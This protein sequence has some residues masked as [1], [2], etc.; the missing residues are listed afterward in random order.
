M[1]ND[2]IRLNFQHSLGFST[3]FLACSFYGVS[4]KTVIRIET[5]NIFIKKV[6][7]NDL[8]F[9]ARENPEASGELPQFDFY[10]KYDK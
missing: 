10:G 2:F 6:R 5:M 7:Y 9:C 1:R 8:T 4:V 3:H